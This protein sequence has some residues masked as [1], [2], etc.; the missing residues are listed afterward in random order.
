MSNEKFK[1][2]FG[3]AVGDTQATIDG[4]TG[5]ALIGSNANL[6]DF[7]NAQMVVSLDNTGDN[8]V[9]NSAV[10]GEATASFTD[11]NRW[12]V[13]VYGAG[14]TNGAVRSAGI[15][16]HGSVT[17]TTDGGSAVGVRGYATDTHA[18]GFNIGLYG[19]A[20][21]SSV[22]NYG[23]YLNDGDFAAGGS[24]SIVT[25]ANGTITLAPNGSGSV[26]INTANGI[27]TNQTTFPLLNTTATTINAFGAATTLNMGNV[28][29]TTTINGNLVGA[30][31]IQTTRTVTGGGKVVDANG[32][33][34]VNNATINSTQLPVSAF[35]DNTT[36]N[37][38]G[39]LIVREY[40]QNNGSRADTTT[41]GSPN[42]ILE[43]SR[44]TGSPP[45]SMNAAQATIGVNGYGYYDG[46]R[47]SSENGVGSPAAFVAQSGE[48]SAFE[49][50]A[51]TASIS[52]TTMTVTAVSS[53]SIHVGQLI[54]GTG[55]ANGTT[56]TAY[57]N[58]T[59]GGAGT[60]TVSISYNGTGTN[61][62][63]IGSTS[64]TGVGTT[65]GGSRI[66]QLITPI[67]N[68]YSAASRQ[69]YY[70]TAQTAPTTS[71][72][73]TVSV[74]VNASLN[75]LIGNNDTGDVTY[76]NTAGTVVYKGRG[77]GTLQTPGLS[78]TMQGVPAQDT[79]SF[80]GYI[81]NGAGA[82][83]NTLTVTAVSSGVLYVGQRIYATALSNTTPYFI[84]AL[85]SGSGLTGTY[86]VAS[87]F[88]T[89]GTTVGSSGTPVAM[90]GSPDDYGM[91]NKGS[92][93]NVFT[94]R[95]STVATRRAPL[96]TNDSVFNLNATG[97]IGAV[98]TS[99]TTQVGQ[100]QW[101]AKQDF[102][103]SV[104]GSTAIIKTTDTGTLTLANRLSMNDAAAT[105]TT[106]S[107]TITKGRGASGGATLNMG[108]T[109][110][111]EVLLS[112][113]D[114]NIAQMG[115]T[116]QTAFSPGYKYTGLMSSSTQTGSGSQFEMSSR[117][118]A[119][120]GTSTY[121]P[122]Q[123]GW[124]L[125]SFTFSADASTTNTN[126]IQAGFIRAYATENWDST[127]YGSRI[128][129]NVNKPG[130]GGGFEVMNIK[131]DNTTISTDILNI[132]DSTNAGYA[133]F[134]STKASFNKPVVLNGSTSGSVSLSASATG[135]QLILQD[136]GFTTLATISAS[137][138]NF[139]VPVTTEITS[140]TISEGTTYT[141]AA[142]VDNNISVQI[143]TLAGGTTV[144]DLASL[145]GN[146]RGGSYNIL[147]FN[148]TA[149]GT[150]IQ[151]KNTRINTNNLMTHTITTG[152]PRIIINA[153][154]VGDYATATHLVVA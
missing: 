103:T 107:L 118:K 36:A 150:P 42:L 25:A 73:N 110:T 68:K 50:S 74:P 75:M 138:A 105:L 37:R 106:D 53:G 2:K 130:T 14:Y 72:V 80:T 60:Y 29:G 126:Q 100:L 88:Q 48:A 65:A 13:G 18:S 91:L 141:P 41:I 123:S 84:T 4:T 143:N 49:T 145:T 99:T 52:G 69:S 15:L 113:G 44:G 144:I 12:G 83:G 22:G 54:S 6:T 21:G 149:S 154:V 58:N 151:V 33:V 7:P 64:I 121:D 26:A 108:A 10:M 59:F 43:A 128:V 9:Y 127:H 66:V 131:T 137:T 114:V 24:F 61:P 142:T 104:A 47:W 97:Q 139:T 39:R 98:G 102:T 62:A 76:V 122:P 11:T 19:D 78:L 38:N 87:T 77:N 147:V 89:A 153:Y 1:V 71:T 101:L 30:E 86:T 120:A 119:S 55:V 56:I 140:T 152:S 8:H 93:I 117:W 28:G 111:N 67:G 116:W 129:I 85:G 115:S 17:N 124:G 70:I 16:G 136:S 96:K 90:A 132:N 32:D 135:S 82:A 46:S 35:F 109:T 146:S 20:S 34:L 79:C 45:T 51:F 5:V 57:G 81:D 133:R 134:D 40:G 112:V 23:L 94:S 95:K 92:E 31:G 27:T 3:L 63:A 148:N 125:G